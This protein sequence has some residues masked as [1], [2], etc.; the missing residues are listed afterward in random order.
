MT[1]E[2]EAVREAHAALDGVVLPADHPFWADHYPPWDW[3]CRC[4]VVGV[5]RMEYERIQQQDEGRLPE[6]K[7]IIEGERLKLLETQG[8][9]DRGPSSQVDVRSPRER[10]E[11]KKD[12]GKNPPPPYQWNPGDLRIPLES[13]EAH[14]ADDPDT[15]KFFVDAAKGTAL[16]D[17]RSLWEWLSSEA[18]G[19]ESGPLGTPVSGALTVTVTTVKAA[20]NRAMKAIDKVHG[21][22]KL[23]AYTVDGKAGKDAFGSH[24]KGKRHIAVSPSAPH[25][26]LTAVHEAAHMLDAWGLVDGS[27]T[28]D[29]GSETALMAEW[30]AKVQQSKAFSTLPNYT[31]KLDYWQSKKECFARSYAQFIAKRSKDSRLLGQLKDLQGQSFPQQWQDNDFAGIEAALEKVFKLKGWMK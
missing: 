16:E 17:G 8:R 18:L 2:D 27:T 3:G 24:W 11:E 4:Q 29:Y 26:E 6:K 28:S 1:M 7:Q 20:V 23:P 30:W 9:L 21:D 12:A 13:L 10:Y 25:K 15:W 5:S 31:K 22:G 14:Y 19:A